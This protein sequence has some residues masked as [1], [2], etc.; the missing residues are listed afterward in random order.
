[1]LI[2]SETQSRKKYEVVVQYVVVLVRDSPM[3]TYF[4]P[5]ESH[6]EAKDYLFKNVVPIMEYEQER[7]DSVELDVTVYSFITSVTYNSVGTFY[8]AV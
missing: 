4:G 8:T 2:K 6:D 3:H 1:M 7:I 5:F